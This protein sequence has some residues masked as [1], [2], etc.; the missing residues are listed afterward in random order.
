MKVLHYNIQGINGKASQLEL[1][2]NEKNYDVLCLNEH[3]ISDDGL[4]VLNINGYTKVSSFS[5]SI[6]Q[7]G[8]VSMFVK[9]EFC[10][11]VS[12]FP[13]DLLTLCEEINFEVAG[14][15]INDVQFLTIYRS[16]LGDLD[17]YLQKLDALLNRLV[18]AKGVIV[19]GDF[20]VQ[21]QTNSKESQRLKNMFTSYGLSITI[22][23]NTR[24]NACLDNVF[25]NI[26]ESAYNASVVDPLLSDHCAISLNFMCVKHCKEVKE[27]KYRPIT[28]LGLWNFYKCVESI[29]FAFIEDDRFDVGHKFSYFVDLISEAMHLSFN[30]KTSLVSSNKRFNRDNYF[31]D[32]ARR[33]RDTLSFVISLRKQNPLLVSQNCISECRRKYRQILEMNKKDS[34]DKHITNSKNTQK[35]V[36]DIIKRNCPS[37]N[38]PDSDQLTAEDFNNFFCGIAEK[39]ITGL[40]G[41]PILTDG[42][43]VAMPNYLFEFKEISFNELRDIIDKAKSNYSNDTYDLNYKLI[44]CVKNVILIPLTKLI[45]MCIVSCT[46][47]ECLKISRVV[48]IY[49]KGDSNDPSNYRPISLT[50]VL[51]KIFETVLNNQM[52]LYLEDNRLLS[53]VQYGFRKNRSTT[54]AISALVTQIQ[55]GFEDRMYSQV[56]LYDLTKAFD[57]VSH[58]LLIKKLESRGFSGSAVM[59][60]SDYIQG[61]Y[62]YVD[63]KNHSSGRLPIKYGVPQGSV[64][65]PIIFLLYINDIIDVVPD[66]SKLVLFADDTS[67]VNTADS[68]EELESAVGDTRKVV[69]DWF[70]SNRLSV[71]EAKTQTLKCSLRYLPEKSEP[72]KYLGVCIDSGLTWE[73]HAV[74]LTKKLNK[75]IYTIRFLLNITSHEVIM[76]VYYG[77]FYPHLKYAILCWGHSAHASQIFGAQRRCM[78][79]IGRLR[80]MECCRE[81]YKK[82]KIMTLP[83]IYIYECL[84]YL[85]TNIHEYKKHKDDHLYDTRRNADLV[86][87]YH[88]TERARDAI[89][90]Y[91]IKYYNLLP[92]HIKTLPDREF[93]C[94]IRRYLIDKAFYSHDEYIMNNFDDL[95]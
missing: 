11:S 34:N 79:V 60:I 20:N 24:L 28:D 67:T 46:F 17:I 61:R 39:L 66:R 71:N 16:P 22:T 42:P 63:Y 91:S 6:R 31:T 2:L 69:L 5:R 74:Q 12:P 52:R 7:H 25:T 9:S 64:M 65:G 8:G 19:T 89:N 77:Y 58:E 93:K 44:K 70:E 30:Q 38:N 84:T 32:S 18:I 56:S 78:R 82:L 53:D 54:S 29:D 13:F 45:N 49:K 4:S 47:P 87:K 21:F 35:A 51:G 59:L 83:C 62:Q 33:A 76:N 26:S 94:R 40:G 3:W 73:S 72:V 92:N 88:R 95:L 50:P 23:Q 14:A 81:L 43:D 41:Q 48:P 55:D 85:R 1:F 86:L 68:L 37:K 57:C 10:Q 75:I 90:H 80:Y 36:W 15:V 27:L